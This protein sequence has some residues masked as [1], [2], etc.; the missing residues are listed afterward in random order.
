MKQYNIKCLPEPGGG[1]FSMSAALVETNTGEEE[2]IWYKND[3]IMV[4]LE[5]VEQEMMPVPIIEVVET[6]SFDPREKFLVKVNGVCDG[7]YADIEN[8]RGYVA[9]L[10]RMLN[11]KDN[12]NDNN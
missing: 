3:P 6:K 12:D 9:R 8:A 11:I 5:D 1:L 4:K 2:F 7:I 10:K